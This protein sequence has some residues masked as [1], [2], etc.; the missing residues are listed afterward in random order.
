MSKEDYWRDVLYKLDLSPSKQQHRLP[1]V[2]DILRKEQSLEDDDLPEVK[3][4]KYD[5]LIR[6]KIDSMHLHGILHG[7]LHL[8]NI[9]WDIT[10]KEENKIRFIDFETTVWMCHA[11]QTYIEKMTK[12]LELKLFGFEENLNGI[13]QREKEMYLR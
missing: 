7:D 10:A 5:S 11:D 12:F 6:Q 13:I 1:R 9:V 3:D 2:V 8:E 4:T